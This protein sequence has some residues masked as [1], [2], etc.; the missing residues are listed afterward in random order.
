MDTIVEKTI[1][2]LKNGG[3]VIFPTDTVF[4]IGARIDHEQAVERIFMLKKRSV[5][6]AVPILV[7]S[8]TMAKAY[9]EVSPEVERLM[10]RYW[11]G[12]LTIILPAKKNVP[13]SITGGTHTVGLR[14]PNHHVLCN[15][16]EK[17]GVPIIGTSANLHGEPSPTSVSELDPRL[18]PL[19]DYILP[20]ECGGKKSSTI[21]DC[22]RLPW[23]VIRQGIVEISA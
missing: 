17:L 4:G 13:T 1:Q 10:A 12:G 2:V 9:A 3:V 21:L 8:I 7:S 18:T 23:K 22:T 5:T 6:Q 16:I 11:P 14:E 15:I 19:V 20:G